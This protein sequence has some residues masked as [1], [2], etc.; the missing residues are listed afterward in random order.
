MKSKGPT[1]GRGTFVPVKP[2]TLPPTN[3][4]LTTTA[5][6]KKANARVAIA[7]HT[8]PSRRI[9]SDRSAAIRPEITAP[10]SAARSTDMS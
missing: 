9:G 3:G 6:K 4:S 5:S 10:M 2:E 1:S 8:P 7:T